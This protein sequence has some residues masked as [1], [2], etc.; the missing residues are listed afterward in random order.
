MSQNIKNIFSYTIS[1][2]ISSVLMVLRYGIIAKYLGPYY[3]G[4]WGVVKL[5]SEYATYSSVG[6][7]YSV[8]KRV[9]LSADD[10]D[11]GGGYVRSGL[12]VLIVCA[13]VL[14]LVAAAASVLARDFYVKYNLYKYFISIS[15]IAVTENFRRFFES[16]LRGLGQIVVISR[17][18]VAHSV[19]AL[20]TV[21]FFIKYN[22]MGL[23]ASTFLSAFWVTMV[24][25]FKLGR[26]LP[27]LGGWR[28]KR[29]LVVN[30]MFLM[31][32]NLLTFFLLSIDR[33]FVSQYYSVESMGQYS[34]NYNV[35]FFVLL[36][37][38]SVGYVLYPV[39]LKKLSFYNSIQY[40]LEVSLKYN[41][42]FVFVV[43]LVA[44]GFP[45]LYR[46]LPAY[47]GSLAVLRLI[48]LSSA[49]MA[50]VYMINIYFIS[51]NFEKSLNVL[52]LVAIVLSLVLNCIVVLLGLD[53]QYVAVATAIAVAGYV[54]LT[55]VKYYRIVGQKVTVASL[56]ARLKVVGIL[57]FSVGMEM[58]WG[59]AYALLV[60]FIVFVWISRKELTEIYFLAKQVK[61]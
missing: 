15:L 27:C 1:R 60:G 35:S 17:L 29:E 41:V 48:L 25:Y 53:Y 8:N 32:Y 36:A 30:G 13:L 14:V 55:I 16:V 22:I 12:F 5:F 21:I 9:A 40:E 24:S 23:V 42:L 3:L 38:G 49:M 6:V 58:I 28:I 18:S 61:I 26:P 47:S 34:F 2:Y 59:H 56:V 39:A 33:V 51:R 4:V 31:L 37:M 54:G 20:V 11:K 46:V 43:Y 19:I 52:L 57:F 7:A 10:G 45:V 44:I 50:P